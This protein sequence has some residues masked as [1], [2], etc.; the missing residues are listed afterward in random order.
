MSRAWAPHTARIVAEIESKFKL[1]V[2]CSTY[3]GHG[4]TKDGRNGEPFGI[5]VWVSP[6]GQRANQ[7]QEALGDAIQKWL[8]VNWDRLGI[9]YVIWWGWMTYR[10]GEWFV[11]DPSTYKNPLASPDPETVMHRDHVHIQVT[12]EN[13]YTPPKGEAP[14]PAP[15]GGKE[16]PIWGVDVASYQQGIDMRRVKAEGY[17]FAV[18]KATEG[19]YRDGTTYTNPE[20]RR[21]ID[22]AK[23]AGMVVGSYHFLVETPVKAQVDHFLRT[24]GD[25]AGQLIMVDYEAYAAPYAYLSP[26]ED[27]LRKFVQEIQARIGNHPILLYSGQ[28]YWE[29][30]PANGPVTDMGVVTWDA[31]YPYHPEAGIGSVLYHRALQ[32]GFGWG[33]RWGDQEPMIWQFSANGLVA[34]MQIDVNAFRG[35]RA[36]LLALAGAVPPRPAPAPPAPPQPAPQPPPAPVTLAG[37]VEVLTR[38]VEALERRA[39]SPVP[40]PPKAPPVP[41]EPPTE[42]EVVQ[43]NP[44]PEATAPET[45]DRGKLDAVEP[46]L[47]RA[48]IAAVA[49]LVGLFGYAFTT[50]DLDAITLLVVALVPLVTLIAGHLTRAK[51]SPASRG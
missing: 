48:Y 27:T 42:E 26:T 22:S 44:G 10:P 45:P 38:R 40:P 41:V 14:A 24:I 33:K 19:P 32:D 50:E 6:Y 9:R 15:G 13:G 20:Y 16:N 2:P 3:S 23:E 30:H 1:P 47:T 17:D 49:Q 39:S 18:V 29:E 12:E 5:D 51:V 8:E 36:D 25:P 7:S 21:Q 35:T 28:G 11:Y 43:T 4:V 34:G 46:A 31:S 37:K